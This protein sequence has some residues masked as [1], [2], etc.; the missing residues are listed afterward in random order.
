MIVRIFNEQTDVLLELK[1]LPILV[2]QVVAGEGKTYDE[3]CL[4]FVTEAEICRL[5][6]EFFDDPSP[7]DCISFPMDSSSDKGWKILGEI[8]ICPKAA[9]DYIQENGGELN[10]EI[11]LYVVHG[12]LHLLG[13]DDIESEDQSR[14]RLAES[15]HLYALKDQG[16]FLSVLPT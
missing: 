12:L 9:C 2:E 13:Y 11:T 15:K 7:T 3:V 1:S 16:H 8:F 6:E 4:H 14:M 5:H 10:E